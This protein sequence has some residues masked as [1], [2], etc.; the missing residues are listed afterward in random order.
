MSFESVNAFIARWTNASP[1]ERANSQLFLSELCDLLGVP[2][3]GATATE[4]NLTV[5]IQGSLTVGAS[6]GT[7]KVVKGRNGLINL[8]RY[9]TLRR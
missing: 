7:Y 5:I 2:H 4:C 8:N 6:I 1:S 9:Q 3:P